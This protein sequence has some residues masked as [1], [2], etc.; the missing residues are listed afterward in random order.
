MT[1][2]RPN[3]STLTLVFKNHPSPG[4]GG[5]FRLIYDSERHCESQISSLERHKGVTAKANEREVNGRKYWQITVNG[6]NVQEIKSG[7]SRKGEREYYL[8]VRSQRAAHRVS[9]GLG[10]PDTRMVYNKNSGQWVVIVK[11]TFTEDEMDREAYDDVERAQSSGIPGYMYPEPKKPK[12][13]KHKKSR[14]RPRPLIQCLC[15]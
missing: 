11:S 3:Q 2:H 1:R 13:T 9:R 6:L 5:K 4:R 10:L 12:S 14:S 8:T 7:R 15:S